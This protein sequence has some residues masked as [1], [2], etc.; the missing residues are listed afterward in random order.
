MPIATCSKCGA[1]HYGWALKYKVCK[2]C[3]VKLKWKEER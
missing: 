1:R 3:G 2:C